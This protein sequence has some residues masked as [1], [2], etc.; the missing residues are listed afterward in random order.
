MNPIRT[1]LKSLGRTHS[2]LVGLVALAGSSLSFAQEIEPPV[3]EEPLPDDST[4]PVDHPQITLIDG[5]CSIGDG[6]QNGANPVAI[7]EDLVLNAGTYLLTDQISVGVDGGAGTFLILSAGV[8]LK[9]EGTTFISIQRNSMLFAT[10]TA[11][12]PITLTSAQPEA[13]RASGDWGGL[14]LNGNATLNV[15]GG[16]AEGEAGTGSYGGT[17]D[18]DSSGFIQHL[19]VEFG[20]SAVDSDNELNGIAFQGVGSGTFVD[21][22]HVRDNQ[23][24][25]VEFFGG[26][27]NVSNLLLTGNRDDSVDWTQGYRGTLDGIT[28]IQG[29]NGDN[30]IEADGLS[31]DPNALP[32]SSPTL[33]NLTLV[34]SGVEGSAGALFRRGTRVTLEN[35]VISGF[36][37]CLE[38]DGTDSTL[39]A[40]EG[41]LVMYNVVLNCAIAATVDDAGAQA[42]LADPSVRSIG[43]LPPV[44]EDET[45]VEGN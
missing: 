42:L 17:N 10:G 16:V 6:L 7:T 12:E 40:L 19:R 1:N 20:G 33:R 45:P 27:V 3:V 13:S 41:E 21:N 25:G 36:P 5:A 32:L 29:A 34:G 35:A 43:P 8:T 14:V 28:V 31:A 26:T 37:V 11:S 30:G 24:D 23:D 18:A 2:A 22:I 38:V 44:V 9:G 39:A 15:A 4:C